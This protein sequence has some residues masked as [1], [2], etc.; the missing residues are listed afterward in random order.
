MSVLVSLSVGCSMPTDT[1]PYPGECAPIEPVSWFP[2]GNANDAPTN[3]VISVGFNDYPDPDTV[4]SDGLMLT[5]A[6]YWIPGVYR[7]DLVGRA[8]TFQAWSNLISESGYMVHLNPALRS[9]GGCPAIQAQR[10]FR[11]GRSRTTQPAPEVVTLADVQAIFTA[12]CAGG[13]HAA[14]TP[15]AASMPGG[16]GCGGVALPG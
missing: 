6:V 1:T 15:D 11:T 8:V 7:V 16:A 5:T 13:C 10:Q 14:A 2:A 3:P 12:H 9:L 4:D